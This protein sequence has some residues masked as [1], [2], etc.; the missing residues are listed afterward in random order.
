MST[1]FYRSLGRIAQALLLAAVT[2]PSSGTAAADP[3]GTVA[4][5][6]FDGEVRNW[7]D[8]KA[9][10]AADGIVFT[11]D[12]YGNMNRAAAFP[13]SKFVGSLAVDYVANSAQWSWAGWIRPSRVDLANRMIYTEDKAGNLFDVQ[14]DRDRIVVD[15]WNDEIPGKWTAAIGTEP[16]KAGAWQHVAVT[17]NSAGGDLGICIIYLDGKPVFVGSLPR[18]KKT[19]STPG[20]AI[21][22]NIGA[23]S[24]GQPLQDFQGAIDDVLIFDRALTSAEIPATMLPNKRMAAFQAIEIE[25]FGE[26]GKKY[27][28][29]WSDDLLTW[30]DEGAIVVGENKP[31]SRLASTRL[32]PKRTWRF[33]EVP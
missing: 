2:L 24:A 13:D 3:F 1:R 32:D 11:T 5:F 16:V 28:L 12:R 14:L 29:Q 6:R 7:M 19:P 8:P 27:Q 4:E 20:F 9:P 25:F 17:F 23:V 18:V 22:S 26:Q 31:V 30:T 21:G 33:K 10:L 15:T